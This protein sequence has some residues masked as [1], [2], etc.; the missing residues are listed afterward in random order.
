MPTKEVHWKLSVDEYAARNSPEAWT[1][2]LPSPPLTPP[3][4][5]PPP[6]PAPISPAVPLETALEVH[7][8]LA[9]AH[10]LQLDF[11]FPSDAFRCNPQLTDSL[12]AEPACAPP[13]AA[14]C[15][16]IAAG[17]FK[18]VLAV[19]HEPKGAPVTVGD[20]LTAIQRELRTY[21]YGAAPPAAEPYMRRRIETVNG[22]CAGRDPQREAENVAAER[23][24][25]GRVVD[26]LLGHTL[27]AGLAV[28]EDRPDHCW[29]LELTVPERYI[30]VE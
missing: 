22:Y 16:R 26:H 14:L 17:T 28:R 7:P 23:E 2:P 15:I 24:G 1:S 25:K 3:P 12:L 30:S 29:Q 20:V 18:A 13:R 10:A 19:E 21:D 9:A 27:F 5:P 4:A 11:S 6:T 8:A